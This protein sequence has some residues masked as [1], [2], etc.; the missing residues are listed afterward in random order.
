MKYYKIVV[1]LTQKE[2]FIIYE[3]A[4][5]L[6]DSFKQIE[7]TP[8]HLEAIEYCKCRDGVFMGTYQNNNLLAPG[9]IIKTDREPKIEVQKQALGEPEVLPS[10]KEIIAKR[11]VYKHG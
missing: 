6:F 11:T 3:R 2:P 9:V 10:E 4:G 8:T 7:S 5:F 1:D